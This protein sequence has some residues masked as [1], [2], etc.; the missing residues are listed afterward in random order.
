MF[1]VLNQR[2][3]FFKQIDKTIFLV[4]FI[5]NAREK[6]SLFRWLVIN[7]GDGCFILKYDQRESEIRLFM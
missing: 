7:S 2:A 1:F 6:E 5:F 3:F 4:F